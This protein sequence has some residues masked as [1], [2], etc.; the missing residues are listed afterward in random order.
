MKLGL[1]LGGKGYEFAG[2]YSTKGCY[3]YSDGSFAGRAYYGIGGIDEEM[4][5]SALFPQH[6]PDGYDCYEGNI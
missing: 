4:E 5:A 2:D 1:L 6:R 3:A